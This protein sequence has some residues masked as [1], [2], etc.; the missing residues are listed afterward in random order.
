MRPP[1]S[2]SSLDSELSLDGVC[3]NP[4]IECQPDDS[5]PNAG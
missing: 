5:S 2:P 4:G 1:M 3:V